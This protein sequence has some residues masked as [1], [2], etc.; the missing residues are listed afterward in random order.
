MKLANALAVIQGGTT[1]AVKTASATPSS[2]APASSSDVAAEHLKQ[3]LKEATASDAPATKTASHTA[4]IEDLTKLAADVAASEHEAMTKEAM[5]YGASVADG[6]VARLAQ[7]Q[8]AAA[9]LQPSVAEKQ[10]AWAPNAVDGSFEK[11]ASENPDLV[12]E[13]HDLGYE[14]TKSQLMK[15]AEASYV[16]A[17]NATVEGIH[18]FASDSFVAGFSDTLKLIEAA[19]R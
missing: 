5:H 7:Y 4:P 18:K 12:R 19:R 11:F 1:S 14:Q 17:Y 6:F 3:A 9:K 8:E 2:P 10:A 15:L 13:A 16:G